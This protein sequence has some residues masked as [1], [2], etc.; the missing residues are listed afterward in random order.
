MKFFELAV[1]TFPGS[2]C[3]GFGVCELEFINH[4]ILLIGCVV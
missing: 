1:S 2:G 3:T 4:V